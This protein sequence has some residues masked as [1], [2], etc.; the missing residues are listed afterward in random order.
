[1]AFLPSPHNYTTMAN[2]RKLKIHR[3]YQVRAY[4]ITTTI[5]EIRLKGKWLEKLGFRQ[6]QTVIVEELEDTLVIRVD[7]GER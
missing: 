6:G 3:K 5:P 7:K 2:P 4:G 1:M